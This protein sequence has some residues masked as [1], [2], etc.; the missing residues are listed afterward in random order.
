MIQTQGEPLRLLTKRFP[1]FAHHFVNTPSGSEMWC[2]G[3]VDSLHEP[4]C[5]I[6]EVA[7]SLSALIRKIVHRLDH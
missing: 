5:S 1:D 3:A 6:C 4:R 7:P 2:A